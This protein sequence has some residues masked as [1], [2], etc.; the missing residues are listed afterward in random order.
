M[1]KS[2]LDGLLGDQPDNFESPTKLAQLIGVKPDTIGDW[3]RRYPE[4]LPCIKLPG[5]VRIRR[6][7]LIEFLKKVQSG[8]VK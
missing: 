6:A 7:D 8:E 4:A 3:C 5:S 2:I 1:N